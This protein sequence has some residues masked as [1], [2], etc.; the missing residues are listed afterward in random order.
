[1]DDIDTGDQV[2]V[3]N[4]CHCSPEDECDEGFF[5]AD[6][7]PDEERIPD[8]GTCC[9]CGCEPTE[10]NPVRTLIMLD[11]KVPP[12]SGSGWGCF[13]CGLPMEGASAVLCD[14]CAPRRPGDR[15][16]APPKWICT[17]HEDKRGRVEIGSF[18][19]VPHHHDMS[20]HQEC[21]SE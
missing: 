6:D 15:L 9:A 3:D 1:V 18:A 10:Q 11:Y 8:L 13:Q 7:E 14:K 2:A 21:C 19:R 5:C 16:K 12:G 4:C 20:R 17:G